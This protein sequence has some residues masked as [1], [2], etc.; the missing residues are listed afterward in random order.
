MISKRLLFLLLLSALLHALL[1][2]LPGFQSRPLAGAAG[3]RLDPG[4][5]RASSRFT[6]RLRGLDAAAPILP[7]EP[8][9]A[10]EPEPESRPPADRPADAS[11]E[12]EPASEAVSSA[13]DA[14]PK[15]VAAE[16]P[17]PILP[18]TLPRGFDRAAYLPA[19][20]LDVRPSPL[21]P[22][23]IA[24]DDASGIE[25]ERGQIVL[26]L[27]VGADGT[28]D[29]VDVERSDVPPAV[30]AIVAETF[31][32]ARMHPGMK[33]ERPVP[34]RMKVLVEFEVR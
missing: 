30:S 28:V 23:V 27:F 3:D 17:L 33:S 11:V 12:P 4:P 20:Q 6:V 19:D 21:Q 2:A 10:P 13:G 5:E 7:A 32:A 16:V 8:I 34:A 1:L 31:R 29:L 9:A 18:D 26:V 25:R 15:S 14:G 24:F 22:V